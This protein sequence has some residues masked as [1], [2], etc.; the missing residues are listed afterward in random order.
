MW[1]VD[2]R[3]NQK[4]NRLLSRNQVGAYFIYYIFD[5]DDYQDSSSQPVSRVI[6]SV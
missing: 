5:K 3:D 4:I 1:I 2:A 6:V